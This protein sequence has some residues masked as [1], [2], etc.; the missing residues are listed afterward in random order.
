MINSCFLDYKEKYKGGTAFLFF[1]GPSIE[2]YLKSEFHKNFNYE[3]YI[4]VCCNSLIKH[5]V[6]INFDFYFVGD[7]TFGSGEDSFENNPYQ[8]LH[9]SV[10]NKKFF[11]E[12]VI[13]Y[14]IRK[15]PELKDFYKEIEKYK[16]KRYDNSKGIGYYPFD[17]CKEEINQY[18]SISM[19]IMQFILYTGIDRIFI[20]GQDC[21]YTN[22]KSHFNSKS[23]NIHKSNGTGEKA[24]RAWN[25]LDRNLIKKRYNHVD[26]NIVNP[27][28]L[29][30]F[31]SIGDD[32][33]YKKL[34]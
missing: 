8:Y 15:K 3:N 11:R 23:A 12:S 17:I 1:P 16:A 27:V 26:I 22:K 33:I 25:L 14:L 20:I 29:R 6:G 5:D 32:E 2:K 24:M 13:N 4:T 30:I 10:K 28:S 34:R 21:N 31:N 9:Q 18:G 7:H 19:D